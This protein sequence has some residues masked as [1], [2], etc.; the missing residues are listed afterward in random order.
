MVSFR[1]LNLV[2]IIDRVTGDIVW[3]MH[4]VTVGQHHVRMLTRQSQGAGN[5]LLFDN[6][7]SAGAPPLRYR[8]YSRAVE[9]DPSTQ[10]IVW[11]YGHRRGEELFSEFMS[12]VQRLPN[13]NTLITAG[14]TGRSLEITRSGRVV[15]QHNSGMTYRAY[16]APL[17]WQTS[18]LPPFR[19]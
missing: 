5:L 11:S 19:W 3:Y 14:K 12:S 15:W 16:R 7:G 8:P 9:I 18:S 6:G 2:T 13:G 1:E 17:D 10:T 4:N